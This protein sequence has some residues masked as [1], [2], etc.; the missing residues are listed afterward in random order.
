MKIEQERKAKEN[1]FNAQNRFM[2]ALKR[3]EMENYVKDKKEREAQ[4]RRKVAE[5]T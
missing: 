5:D 2:E 1:E 4:Q 3:L